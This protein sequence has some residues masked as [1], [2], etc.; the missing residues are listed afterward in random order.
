MPADLQ[1][2]IHLIL[3]TSGHAPLLADG[4]LSRTCASIAATL[5]HR[6]CSV[7]ATGGH[8]DHI[9][10]LFRPSREVSLNR[11]AQEC[12]C[13]S[14]RYLVRREGHT[15]VNQRALWQPGFFAFS[16]SA[17]RLDAVTCYIR[18]Q[19]R[20]HLAIS[21]EEELASLNAGCPASE[22]M[23]SLAPRAEPDYSPM[24]LAVAAFAGSPS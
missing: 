6:G 11:L 13:V 22:A 4:L 10:I 5:Q 2:Y 12:Q 9:H 20:R 17:N 18:N 3:T 24:P 16:V 23:Q 8:H 19:Q 15:F 7:L 14:E 21:L 1:V